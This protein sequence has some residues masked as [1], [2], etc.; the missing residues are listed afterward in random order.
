MT[1]IPTHK[2]GNIISID[3]ERKTVFVEPNVTMGQ[4]TATIMPLGEASSLTPTD[5]E[6]R[7]GRTAG[8]MRRERGRTMAAFCIRYEAL[9]R[10]Q[11]AEKVLLRSCSGS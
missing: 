7:R 11:E 8:C 6:E 5:R 10:Q 2:L 9:S 4:L 3:E 1:G